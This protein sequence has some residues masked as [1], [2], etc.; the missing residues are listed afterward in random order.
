MKM[1]D[2]EGLKKIAEKLREAAESIEEYLSQ[3]RLRK[4]LDDM[5]NEGKRILPIY[6]PEEISIGEEIW[7]A[8]IYEDEINKRW[9]SNWT[10]T[11]TNRKF[12]ETDLENKE[13]EE[14]ET[15]D[16]EIIVDGPFSEDKIVE[17]IDKWLRERGYQFEVRLMPKED[18]ISSG[19]FFKDLGET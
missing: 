3:K 10:W 2:E 5:W 9:S 19:V 4:V 12:L 11:V 14:D 18:A 7:Y 8:D 15:P 6:Y 13:R 17:A 1:Q 16:W